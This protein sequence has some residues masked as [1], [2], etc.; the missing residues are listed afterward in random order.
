MDQFLV[1][2]EARLKLNFDFGASSADFFE[3]SFNS[4]RKLYDQYL[5]EQTFSTNWL[6]KYNL[7]YKIYNKLCPLSRL[8]VQSMIFGSSN[9]TTSIVAYNK[10]VETQFTKFFLTKKCILKVFCTLRKN[11]PLWLHSALALW[12]VLHVQQ[13]VLLVVG[14]RLLGTVVVVQLTHSIFSLFPSAKKENNK[15]R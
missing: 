14:V 5:V 13:L 9:Q 8:I 15:K 2:L 3:V 1:W 6:I 4:F 10:R 11:S 12:L 7:W